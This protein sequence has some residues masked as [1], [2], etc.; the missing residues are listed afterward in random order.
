MKRFGLVLVVMVVAASVLFWQSS[1][2]LATGILNN[3][4]KEAEK[5]KEKRSELDKQAEVL[6]KEEADLTEITDGW[7]RAM[8][9]NRQEVMAYE[10]N[11]RNHNQDV[12][13]HKSQVSQ[14]NA[15]PPDARNHAAVNA[16]NQNKQRLDN[17]GDRIDT[18][19]A[20]LDQRKSDLKWAYDRLE[21]NRVKNNQMI[22]DWTQKRNN[23]QAAYN[24][25]AA[26]IESL[27]KQAIDRCQIL[28]R[29]PQ[30]QKDAL[31]WGCGV[32]FDGSDP[33]LPTLEQLGVYVPPEL[34]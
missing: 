22:D 27:K 34:R 12:E 32:F 23:L 5:I 30:T 24:R 21:G 16:Y 29:N 11:V 26:E 9:V 14:H 6:K 25:L 2:A 7:K 15:N 18:N 19:K 31:A 33:S 13:R 8:D 20:K 4:A 3:I 17:W 28:L 1:P 10:A